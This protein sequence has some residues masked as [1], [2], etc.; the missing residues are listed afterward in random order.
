VPAPKL[1]RSYIPTQFRSFLP[2]LSV[3]MAN[4]IGKRTVLSKD[5]IPSTYFQ[6]G[7]PYTRMWPFTPDMRVFTKGVGGQRI[8]VHL[9]HAR[10]TYT[11]VESGIVVIEAET[12][13]ALQ[14]ML[15]DD[16]YVSFNANNWSALWVTMDGGDTYVL[17]KDL[18]HKYAQRHGFTLTEKI[19]KDVPMTQ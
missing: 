11:I 9:N 19:R 7:A 14:R 6:E 18:N 17:A 2:L 13:H 4:T 15:Y 10:H 3:T 1:L 8:E 5:D 16:G 12:P